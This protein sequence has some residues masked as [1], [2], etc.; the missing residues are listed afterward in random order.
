M[1]TCATNAKQKMLYILRGIGGLVALL[2]VI[3]GAQS[4]LNIA[5][6]P[7]PAGA[8]VLIALTFAVYVAW[9]RFAAASS[10]ASPSLHSSSRLLHQ[11][12]HIT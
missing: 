11:L 9:V 6:V 2:L 7:R 10:A 3:A 5:H 1:R 4:L 12:A 8:V